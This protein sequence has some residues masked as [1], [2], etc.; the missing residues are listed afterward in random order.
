MSTDDCAR[1][2]KAHIQRLL[3]PFI[4]ERNRVSGAFKALSG[5]C[6]EGKRTW[7]CWMAEAEPPELYRMETL[8]NV[9]RFLFG[10]AAGDCGYL[11]VPDET[12]NLWLKRGGLFL[13][14]GI[15][16]TAVGWKGDG[17]PEAFQIALA[18]PGI[19]LFLSPHGAGVLSL[20]FEARQPADLASLRELS[21]RLSQGRPYTSYVFQLPHAEHN[22]NPPPSAEVSFAERLGQAGGGFRIMELAEF[23]LSPLADLGYEPMQE[24]FSVYAVTR[25][26]SAADFAQPDVT[27]SLR[28]FLTALAHVE[29]SAHPGSLKVSEHILNPRHWVATGS[30]AAAHLVADQ[31]PPHPYDEQRTQTVLHKYFIPYLVTLLQR[32]ALQGLLREACEAVVADDPSE[33]QAEKATLESAWG[34]AEAGL[35][36]RLRGLNRHALAFTV[37]GCFTEVSSREAHNQYYELVQTALRVRDSFGSV[38]QALRDAEAMDNDRFQA[39]TLVEIG[40]LTN[41]LKELLEEAG[42]NARLVAH[43][44]SKVE[45]LE[46]FFVSYYFTALMFYVNHDGSLFSHDY[47]V[48]TLAAAPLVSG[49][50]A[51]LGLKPHRLRHNARHGQEAVTPPH[52]PTPRADEHKERAWMFLLALIAVFALWLGLGLQY[53]PSQPETPEGD[54]HQA[55]QVPTRHETPK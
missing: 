51:F 10:G 55:A 33:A 16:P 44:Q 38:Q 37:N 4:Y 3:L 14:P 50:I 27:E 18:A 52:R 49:A 28:P 12:A 46:V 17:C 31:D 8:P 5:L 24:Q 53:C 39:R 25:F 1:A 19:E 54:G 9:R 23:L 15:S 26:G 20:T 30:L 6:W 34:P 29:E 11:R 41:G 2:P 32:V 45:W 40:S 22:P 13:K 43:V 48:W 35:A 42:T 7:S 47:S 21:Y 36:A